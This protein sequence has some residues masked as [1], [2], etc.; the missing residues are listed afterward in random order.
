MT[1][2]EYKVVIGIL[3]VA[4]IACLIIISI[5][6]GEIDLLQNKLSE[7]S[8]TIRALDDKIASIEAAQEKFQ[9]ENILSEKVAAKGSKYI[10]GG[11]LTILGIAIVAYFGGIDPG[12]LGKI[13]NLS[14]DQS[15]A[16]LITQ[17][18]LIGKNLKLC[19]LNIDF[20]YESI[21][22]VENKTDLVCAKLEVILKALINKDVNLNSILGNL[23][24]DK[25]KDWE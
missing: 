24:S 12:N 18:D 17:N 8:D 20:I 14:A 5:L 3:L 15:T 2:R 22:A 11:I 21:V 16:D 25:G 13:I 23:P 10:F 19:L 7:L 1:A 9:K 6:C 4:N